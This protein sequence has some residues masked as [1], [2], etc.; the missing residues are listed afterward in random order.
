VPFS[1]GVYDKRNGYY[2]AK[3]V[4]N[5]T[6]LRL[7]DWP[8]EEQAAAAYDSAARFYRGED[9]G[10]NGTGAPP[11]SKEELQRRASEERA[12]GRGDT[13]VYR[14]VTNGSERPG[15]TAQIGIGGWPYFLGRFAEEKQ[16]AHA[17]DMAIRQYRPSDPT[18][19]EGE[20]AKTVAEIRRW[21]RRLRSE[22]G[23]EGTS[24][25]S[26][27]RGVW[28]DQEQQKWAAEIRV[29]YEKKHIGRFSDETEAAKA[30][31]RAALKLH[32]RAN[33]NFPPSDYDV[34]EGEKLP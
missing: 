20:E 33:T 29:D 13:S 14:G 28:W 23:L 15:W 18:N 3:I 22:E 7:G 31:D 6:H 17:A 4:V 32:D 24:P 12:L 34:E 2:P 21:A 8:T 5:G 27:Y 26:E 10:R 25:A 11:R 9:A 30:Y 19:F 16:A 1:T